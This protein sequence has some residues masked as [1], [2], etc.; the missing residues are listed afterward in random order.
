MIVAWPMI[1]GDLIPTNQNSS[2]LLQFPSMR[3]EIPEYWLQSIPY[4]NNLI[5]ENERLLLLPRSP[6]FQNHYPWYIGIDPPQ[7]FYDSALVTADPGAGKDSGIKN[8]YGPYLADLLYRSIQDADINTFEKLLNLTQVRGILNRGDLDSTWFGY[9]VLP[10]NSPE[11]INSFL[12]SL[13][14][15]SRDN[16]LGMLTFYRNNALSLPMIWAS[17]ELVLSDGGEAVGLASIRELELPQQAWL[18]RDVLYKLP[19][20][21]QTQLDERVVKSISLKPSDLMD[22][23]NGA[24]D[25]KLENELPGSSLLTV[26]TQDNQPFIKWS[27]ITGEPQFKYSIIRNVAEDLSQYEDFSFRVYS[28]APQLEINFVLDENGNGAGDGKYAEFFTTLTPNRWQDITFNKMQLKYV[29]TS[30]FS[31]EDWKNVKRLRFIECAL[32]ICGN[33]RKGSAYS[34]YIR[35]VSV[36]PILTEPQSVPADNGLPKIS[37]EKFNSTKYIA[38]IEN[39]TKPY[40]LILGQSFHPWWRAIIND[41]TIATNK[42]VLID[43]YANGWWIEQT[44]NYEVI[45]D[46]W[47]QTWLYIGIAISSVT[48]LLC[49]GYLVLSVGFKIKFGQ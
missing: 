24:T 10:R 28:D 18:S 21:F 22:L 15:V 27:F 7:T 19:G 47:P 34:L 39:A 46:Y 43:G 16:V 8:I 49:I 44:G 38:H 33:V 23:S 4:V 29:N 3:V 42:H 5:G 32:P 14:F 6:S 37:F 31:V 20:D 41:Q 12:N 40:F 2:S 48:L 25:W 35:D 26:V 30:P 45:L 9:F 17:N 1:T 13:S 36:V 11:E